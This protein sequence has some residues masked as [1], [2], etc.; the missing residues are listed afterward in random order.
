ME[1][2]GKRGIIRIRNHALNGEVRESAIHPRQLLLLDTLPYHC[3]GARTT[4]SVR[5]VPPSETAVRQGMSDN[6]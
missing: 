5:E 2:I 3:H 1:E 4:V 6:G